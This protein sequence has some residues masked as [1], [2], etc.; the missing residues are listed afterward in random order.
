MKNIKLYEEFLSSHYTSS[1]LQDL[2]KYL[3]DN[4]DHPRYASIDIM[5]SNGNGVDTT[6]FDKNA[7]PIFIDY[8][9]GEGG[10]EDNFSVQLSGDKFV[11]NSRGETQSFGLND[12]SEIVDFITKDGFNISRKDTT[13]DY[14]PEGNWADT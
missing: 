2:L 1:K 6:S 12:Y 5:D 4:I 10:N 14:S 8:D 13:I 3:K 7:E 11:V 9:D